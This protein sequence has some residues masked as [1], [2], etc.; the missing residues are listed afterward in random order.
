MSSSIAVI[1][2]FTPRPESRDALRVLLAGMTGPTR[3]EDGC[4]T[5]DLYESADGAELVLFER[6]RDR[7]ALDEH[8]GSAHYRSYREQ[9]PALLSEP[10]A[11]T[12]LSPL[13]EAAGS[14]RIQRR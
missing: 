11:V 2:R 13:D 8:R 1:A 9:L 14:E 3:A 12:V 6:Y 10:I 5:Y 4:R 7:S